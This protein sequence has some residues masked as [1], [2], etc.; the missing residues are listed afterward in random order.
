MFPDP[1]SDI[2]TLDDGR[3]ASVKHS[4]AARLP[5]RWILKLL[6]GLGLLGYRYIFGAGEEGKDKPVIAIQAYPRVTSVDELLQKSPAKKQML[7]GPND[8]TA[9]GFPAKDAIWIDNANNKIYVVALVVNQVGYTIELWVY[10][11]DIDQFRPLFEQFLSSIDWNYHHEPRSLGEFVASNRAERQRMRESQGPVA[12][13]VGLIITAV[14][15]YLL[16]RM[17][18][19]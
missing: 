16:I 2:V 18:S 11:E 12:T 1:F 5:H 15:V 8:R 7:S 3:V 9:S 17:L 6:P 14:I 13:I 4:F 10:D 19:G